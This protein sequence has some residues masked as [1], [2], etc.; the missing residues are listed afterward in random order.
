[1]EKVK[2]VLIRLVHVK[3]FGSRGLS[4]GFQQGD[5]AGK[6]VLWRCSLFV[7]D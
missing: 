2:R 4:E 6:F 1:M 3:D 7:V 5:F